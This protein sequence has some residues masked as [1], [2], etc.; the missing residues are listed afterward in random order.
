MMFEDPRT[1][2]ALGTAAIMLFAGFLG[3]IPSVLRAS[4]AN[5]LRVSGW[6]AVFTFSLVAL[7]F[8]VCLLP[9]SLAWLAFVLLAGTV[10][11]VNR[12][13]RVLAGQG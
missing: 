5:R 10:V 7:C 13:N 3:S 2:A 9:I 11:G 6:C 12:A 1:F 4:R 8:A